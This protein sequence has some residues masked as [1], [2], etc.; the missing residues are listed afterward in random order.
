MASLLTA[1][2]KT[3]VQEALGNMHDTFGKTISVYVE[4]TQ[5]VPANLNYNPLYGRTKDQS[6]SQLNKILTKYDFTAR[7]YYQPEQKESIVDFG[8][9]SNLVA[10]QGMVRIKVKEDAFEKIKICS[11]IEINKVLY[12]VASDLKLEDQINQSFYSVYLKREN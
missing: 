8:A 7:V 11:K 12:T 2:Q 1:A 10:S 5:S 6:R 9:Q 3:A 4:E